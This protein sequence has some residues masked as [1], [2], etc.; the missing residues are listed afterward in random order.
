MNAAFTMYGRQKDDR[1]APEKI[2]VPHFEAP[3]VI[4]TGAVKHEGGGVKAPQI[5]CKDGRSFYVTRSR[6]KWEELVDAGETVFSENEL[7]RLSAACKECDA[8][9]AKL[10]ANSVL[11]LKAVFGGAYIRRG[12]EAIEHYGYKTEV[13]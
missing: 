2:I 1:T 11:D 6:K 3:S 10:L 4:G 13:E 8:E 5:V 7:S 9:G 12:G